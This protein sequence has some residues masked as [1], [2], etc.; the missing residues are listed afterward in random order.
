ML[1][2]PQSVKAPCEKCSCTTNHDILFEFDNSGQ[3]EDIIWWEYYQVIRCRG[4]ESI[5]FRKT[6]SSTE[7]LDSHGS[8]IK[9]VGIYPPRIANRRLIKGY[10]YLPEKVRT[11]YLEIHKAL[12]MGAVILGGIGIRAI[13]EAVCK[14][15]C[16]TGKN[17][18]KKID[19][20]AQNGYLSKDRADFLHGTR[21]MGNIAAH[22]VTPPKTEVLETAL[23]IVDNLLQT[24]YILP[25]KRELLPEKKDSDKNNS[26]NQ[27][28]TSPF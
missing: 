18:E 7:D 17:L 25:K 28:S 2:R 26:H 10:W 3:N 19:A 16:P 1:K 6:S 12:A 13:V 14:D 15:R 11:V 23:D 22:E 5:A 20:L 8:P 27:N 21:L 24:V 4:C 9:D